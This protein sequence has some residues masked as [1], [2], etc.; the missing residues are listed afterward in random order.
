[1]ARPRKFTFDMDFDNPEPRHNRTLAAGLARMVEAQQPET[2]PPPPEPELPPAPTFSE[3]DL[4]EAR[5]EAF[6]AGRMAVL[7]DNSAMAAQAL[8]H[9][10]DALGQQ[11]VGLQGAL[12]NNYRD[13]AELA[14]QVALELCRK[15]LPHTADHF[16]VAEIEALLNSLLPQ[17]MEHPRLIIRI[18][19]RLADDARVRLDDVCRRHG[20]EGRLQIIEQAH[21]AATD[22]LL[23]WGD[24]GA[25]RNSR[26]LWDAIDTLVARTLPRFSRGEAHDEQ[27]LMFA[28]EPNP[29]I[30]ASPASASPAYYEEPE[31]NIDDLKELLHG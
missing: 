27:S 29:A 8:T 19:P 7:N 1:M 3:A 11:F 31:A 16:V 9:A 17:L 24:G 18:H 21:M 2:P 12:D 26:R 4:H 14:T 6:E 10:L 20:F 22:T 28:D 30:P 15:L 13:I 5:Q 25:E 23:E